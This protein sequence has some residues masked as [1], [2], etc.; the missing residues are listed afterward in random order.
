MLKRL[1]YV[2]RY[3]EVE[4]QNAVGDWVSVKRNGTVDLPTRLANEMA[5]QTDNWE[6]VDLSNAKTTDPKP[7]EKAAQPAEKKD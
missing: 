3:S 2:G 1:K 4:F 7:E 6:I 5:E